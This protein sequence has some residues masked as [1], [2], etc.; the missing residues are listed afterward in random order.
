MN[1]IAQHQ[2]A[3]HIAAWAAIPANLTV[4]SPITYANGN[5]LGLQERLSAFTSEVRVHERAL[6]GPLGV[7]QGLLDDFMKKSELFRLLFW[8]LPLPWL[9]IDRN[10]SIRVLEDLEPLS[11]SL[12]VLEKAVAGWDPSDR[13]D[14]GD[15]LT[16][17]IVKEVNVLRRSIAPRA[18]LAEEIL[19]LIQTEP[20]E[21]VSIF[22]NDSIRHLRQFNSLTASL[23]VYHRRR[24]SWRPQAG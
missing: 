12:R 3:S 24:P 8:Q 7:E 9:S 1:A 11:T 18:S 15:E 23:E 17:A 4:N 19:S 2:L 13:R 14:E 10:C 21:A 5:G 6:L 22:Y 20:E 16:L